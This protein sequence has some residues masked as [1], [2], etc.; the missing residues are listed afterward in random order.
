MKIFSFLCSLSAA[1]ALLCCAPA[2]AVNTNKPATKPASTAPSAPA[3]KKKAPAPKA[4]VKAE[5][6]SNLN[7]V[8]PEQKLRFVANAARFYDEEQEQKTLAETKKR[9]A[10]Y[11]AGT[12]ATVKSFV[13]EIITHSDITGCGLEYGLS[14]ESA[15]DE[16]ADAPHLG[17][18]RALLVC[19]ALH[20]Q[21]GNK[22]KT[23]GGEKS[24]FYRCYTGSWLNP[25]SQEGDAYGQQSEERKEANRRVEINILPV[26]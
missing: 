21:L 26:D 2:A 15:V 17:M 1:A 24:L 12:P 10:D 22:I 4:P 23:S 3:K 8:L 19:N 20:K 13:V 5:H 16:D 18:R 7:L 25:I 14:T 9:I 11:A 6:A